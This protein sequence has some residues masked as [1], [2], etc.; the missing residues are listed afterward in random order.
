LI[1]KEGLAAVPNRSSGERVARTLAER[2]TR[3]RSAYPT[4]A[5]CSWLA[6]AKV[7]AARQARTRMRAEAAAVAVAAGLALAAAADEEKTAAPVEMWAAPS[8]RWSLRAI[9]WTP[10]DRTSGAPFPLRLRYRRSED[11]LASHSLRS[12][13]AHRGLGQAA[14]GWEWA[15]LGPCA[16][17][18]HFGDTEGCWS[19]TQSGQAAGTVPNGARRTRPARSRAR[20]GRHQVTGLC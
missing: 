16:S 1:E 17:A 11:S 20:G 5:G 6:L 2:L 10:K 8:V 19:E 14:I 15:P 3:A 18:S 12:C 9:P 7:V 13:R 4:L